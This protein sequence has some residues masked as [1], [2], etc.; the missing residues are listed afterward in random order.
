MKYLNIFSLIL[1]FILVTTSCTYSQPIG[2]FSTGYASNK[3]VVGHLG[4]GAAKGRF[5]ATLNV[6]AFAVNKRDVPSIF[7]LRVGYK[8][9]SFEIFA[10]P[11][12]EFAGENPVK[13]EKDRESEYAAYSKETYKSNPHSD[14]RLAYGLIKHFGVLNVG[15]YSTGSIYSLQIGLRSKKG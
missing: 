9:S 15:V 4:I 14:I 10:G 7:D 13:D 6:S 2:T 12:Y 5:N 3:Q 11:A 1:F 8:V